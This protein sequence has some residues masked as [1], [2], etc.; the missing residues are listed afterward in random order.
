MVDGDRTLRKRPT[1]V[2]KWFAQAPKWLFRARL[3]F[4]FGSRFL[5][6]EHTGR[7]SG[8]VFQTP[9]EITHHNSERD[10]Y[11]V[12]SGYGEKS[13][14]YRNLKANPEAAIWLGTRRLPATARRLSTDE[15][16]AAM[17]VYEGAHPKAA[18][19]LESYVGVSHDDSE[20]SWSAMMELIPMVGLTPQR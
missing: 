16:V 15:A 5:L 12:C 7:R 13:D 17:K 8:K 1:G 2:A 3:G 6:L 14:W 4:V 20:A 18:S 19:K 11:I 10:E 9:L